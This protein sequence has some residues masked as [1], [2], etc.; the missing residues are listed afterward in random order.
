MDFVLP[1]LVKVVHHP[2]YCEQ[3][4]YSQHCTLQ[5]IPASAKVYIVHA[6]MV[7]REVEIFVEHSGILHDAQFSQLLLRCAFCGDEGILRR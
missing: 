4:L 7:Y 6:A 2:S 1:A 5:F 3:A